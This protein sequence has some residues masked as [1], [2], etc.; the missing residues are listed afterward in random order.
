MN[1]ITLIETGGYL[2]LFAIIFA[3]SSFVFFLPGDS[4]LFTAGFLASQNIL[5]LPILIISCFTAAV[6]G[7]NVGYAFGKRI[8]DRFFQKQD[9]WLFSHKNVLKAQKFYEKHGSLTIVIARFIPV[10]RTFV[11]IVA[12]I[13]KMHYR[14]FVIFNFVGAVLW[15]IGLNVAGYFLG[16]TIPNADKYLT[17]IVILIVIV[18]VAPTV[19]HVLKD[20]E[21]R[22]DLIKTVQKLLRK[23]SGRPI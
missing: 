10:V 9:S 13:G 17:P 14:T 23:M 6:I 8:G 19:V 7:N 3:E 18:S 22:T 4:L 1:I 5:S 15:S 2:G 11:P 12:G 21:T 20:Q 16:K